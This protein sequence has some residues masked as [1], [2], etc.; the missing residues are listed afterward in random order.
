MARAVAVVHLRG[1][2]SDGR[3]AKVLAALSRLLPKIGVEGRGLFACDLRGTERLLG[4]PERVGARII[5]TLERV[6]I[7]CAVGIAERPFA[8]RV[9]AERAP[10]G[11]V[12]RIKP[13]EERAFLALLP[14]PV[15]PLDEEPREELALL[16][17]R[18]VGAFAELDPGAVLDRFGHAVAAAHALARGEDAGEVRGTP[19]RRRIVARRAWDA[20][21]AQR[22]QLL[23]ALK[24]VLDEISAELT[25]DGLAAMRLE[26]RLEREDAPVLRIERL[27][28]PPTA[29]AFALLR[30]VRWGLEEMPGRDEIGHV[31]GVRVEVTE[32]EP[33][34]GRQIGLFAPDGASEEEA[35]A[36][37][38]YLR[39]RL[40]PGAVVRATVSDA[41]ARLAEREVEWDEVVS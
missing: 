9:A 32:V 18:T 41:D 10:A 5:A 27:V 39:S 24:S 11:G 1:E 29:A 4:Q 17:I 13:G 7:P 31:V 2:V 33:A 36:V 38:R 34:R 3:H 6:R 23:F 28:L 16:G 40:G 14:L 20:P 22:D 35:I 12:V 25:Q 19:P 37:A 26:A 21:M 30:S 15:L 8:A